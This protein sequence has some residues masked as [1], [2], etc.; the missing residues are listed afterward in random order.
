MYYS[1]IKVGEVKGAWY[2]IQVPR[3]TLRRSDCQTVR[4]SHAPRPGLCQQP[5][6]PLDPLIVFVAKSGG[7]NPGYNGGAWHGELTMLRELGKGVP[8]G[9]FNCRARLTLEEMAAACQR[10][11]YILDADINTL[12]YGLAKDVEACVTG[13]ATARVYGYGAE[14]FTTDRKWQEFNERQEEAA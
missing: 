7:I 11:G 9:T 4:L 13:D 3:E 5:I 6:R 10:E 2:Y 8:P 14:Q 12:L 1:T